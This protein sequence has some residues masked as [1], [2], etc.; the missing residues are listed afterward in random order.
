MRPDEY[1][2]LLNLWYHLWLKPRPKAT[3]ESLIPRTKEY[4]K[5][6][7]NQNTDPRIYEMRNGRFRY[8]IEYIAKF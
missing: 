4:E 6:L 2:R 3:I 7:K 5:W 8:G 1:A